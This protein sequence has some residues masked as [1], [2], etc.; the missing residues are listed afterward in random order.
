MRNRLVFRVLLIVVVVLFYTPCLHASAP[1]FEAADGGAD[2]TCANGRNCF[3]LNPYAGHHVYYIR[4]GILYTKR[5]SFHVDGAEL[6]PTE[7]GI[8]AAPHRAL[9]AGIGAATHVLCTRNYVVVLNA[10]QGIATYRLRSSGVLFQRFVGVLSGVTE[11]VGTTA[12][13]FRETDGLF[14]VDN[15]AGA[16]SFQSHI[17][18]LNTRGVPY[19]SYTIAQSDEQPVAPT[20]SA[21][22]NHRSVTARAIAWYNA[23]YVGVLNE[24]EASWSAPGFVEASNL[25][26]MVWVNMETTTDLI[27]W[28]MQDSLGGHT[29]ATPVPFT[30]AST[31]QVGTA[32][33]SKTDVGSV[34]ARCDITRYARG[35]DD[36]LLVC[37]S[38][39]GE[40]RKL[41]VNVTGGDAGSAEWESA[42]SFGTVAGDHISFGEQDSIYISAASTTTTHVADL[43]FSNP[44]PAYHY[45]PE[46]HRRASTFVPNITD[47]GGACMLE[48][49]PYLL[50]VGGSLAGG[51]LSVHR[52][53]PLDF[54]L[55]TA[56]VSASAYSG[57]DVVEA[58]SALCMGLHYVMSVSASYLV[59]FAVDATTHALSITHN[60]VPDGGI[61]GTY[62]DTVFCS[63]IDKNMFVIRRDTLLVVIQVT[64]VGQLV[65]MHT[66]SLNF[67]ISVACPVSGNNL[68]MLWAVTPAE[69]YVYSQQAVGDWTEW[70]T[71]L[72]FVIQDAGFDLEL[73]YLMAVSH[74]DPTKTT[75]I[76]AGTNTGSNVLLHWVTATHGYP[77]TWTGSVDAVSNFTDTLS[78][79][80]PYHMA[81]FDRRLLLVGTKTALSNADSGVIAMQVD[82]SSAQVLPIDPATY[83]DFMPL[84]YSGSS[85]LVHPF[86]RA[87]YDVGLDPDTRVYMDELST[88][89]PMVHSPVA[90]EHLVHSYFHVN[91]TL[92]DQGLYGFVRFA[93]AVTGNTD[94]TVS[95]SYL[96]PGL[97]VYEFLAA[98]VGLLSGTYNISVH[99][100][101]NLSNA[102]VSSY[103]T[104]DFVNVT[105]VQCTGGLDPLTAC[106]TCL[107]R[108]ASSTPPCI[109][110]ASGWFG[111]DCDVPASTCAYTRCNNH[112][113][114]TGKL[115]GCVCQ[116]G[117]APHTHEYF[118]AACSQHYVS[119][120]FN[121]CKQRGYCLGQLSGCTCHMGYDEALNCS[122]CKYGHDS[123]NN[124]LTCLNGHLGGDCQYTVE[125]CINARCA[126][127]GNCTGPTTGCDCYGRYN[128]TLNCTG[129]AFCAH[130]GKSVGVLVD[131]V[132]VCDPGYDHHEDTNQ[133]RVDGN[134]SSMTIIFIV[135]GSIAGVLLA[136]F[137]YTQFAG[138]TSH[139]GYTP[140]QH[141]KTKKKKK[142]KKKSPP[143][144]EE[145]TETSTPSPRQYD[146]TDEW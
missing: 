141:K 96:T 137:L 85:V 117:S 143:Q 112:G 125:T 102:W 83:V 57:V 146:S 90:G 75:V 51:E 30:F 45:A 43:N 140:H 69:V 10:T 15:D 76:A 103:K 40:A 71:P 81:L 18:I 86:Q 21:C 118:G 8:T 54:T 36:F 123:G 49:H 31:T 20:L 98:Q 33:T 115:A 107:S 119:C 13:A 87:F 134:A 128:N 145:R 70:G 1:S 114:C 73:T 89:M 91:Y 48:R 121:R 132:C 77:P 12:C 116:E 47:R 61:P 23:S 130:E 94:L 3:C 136:I 142:K 60:G 42:H 78:P 101:A 28:W 35:G 109:T 50:F 93:S 100:L 79:R 24:Y 2:V 52:L 133:C 59:V 19:I 95:G 138:K 111:A 68:G 7:Y 4:D 65:E 62:Y 110:C 104:V 124:C 27:L 129:D 99:V 64:E 14:V 97:H 32:G 144:E 139:T 74:A 58:H 17:I 113:S 37:E 56:A 55:V 29:I 84:S 44:L 9:S 92:Y 126:S 67:V 38:T 26:D 105:V 127:R 106:A 11:F 41:A 131:G 80:V 108:Y 53:D 135:V 66:L 120:D 39:T 34:A 46:V 22:F 122:T 16:G 63:F 82:P 88:W 72:S 5:T 6:D 25:T